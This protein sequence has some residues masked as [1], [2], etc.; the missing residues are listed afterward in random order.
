MA[1]LCSVAGSSKAARRRVVDSFHASGG[2]FIPGA[3]LKGLSLII[4]GNRYRC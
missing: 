3:S 2:A 1:F 4:G